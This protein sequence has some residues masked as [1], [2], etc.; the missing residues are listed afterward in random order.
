[1]LFSEIIPVCSEDCTKPIN[2]LL[3]KN[4]EFLN[5]NILSRHFPEGTEESHKALSQVS[6]SL[7]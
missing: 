6:Q 2:A 3:G 4:A 7:G 5:I 1:M